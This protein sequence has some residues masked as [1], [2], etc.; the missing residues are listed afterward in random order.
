M[1]LELMPVH[2]KLI[3]LL[4]VGQPAHENQSRQDK[5]GNDVLHDGSHSPQGQRMTPAGTAPSM[6]TTMSAAVNAP[7]VAPRKV[8][9][10]KSCDW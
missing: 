4:G 1:G 3:M 2:A 10:S 8:R 9:R 7:E 6:M 5:T